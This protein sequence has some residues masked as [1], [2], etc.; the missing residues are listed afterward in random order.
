MFSKRFPAVSDPDDV[1]GTVPLRV[2][3]ELSARDTPFL[4]VLVS[5]LVTES[6]LFASPL[7]RFATARIRKGLK[8]KARSHYQHDL[9]GKARVLHGRYITHR[10]RLH[11][12]YSIVLIL[13]MIL[14]ACDAAQEKRQGSVTVETAPASN[15]DVSPPLRD[16]P[17]A[18]SAPHPPREVPIGR[19]PP[20][21]EREKPA[22]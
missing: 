11:A 19:I 7:L 17:P 21:G 5:K 8:T 1:A 6:C 13:T 12:A 2:I 9:Q 3:P 4:E 18:A 15:R 10:T 20:P 14:A 16:M 22:R